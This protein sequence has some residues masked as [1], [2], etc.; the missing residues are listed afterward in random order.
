MYKTGLTNSSRVYT[1]SL[2]PIPTPIYI[3]PSTATRTIV[4]QIVVNLPSSLQQHSFFPALLLILLPHSSH[5]QSR[6]QSMVTSNTMDKAAVK[7]EG[8]VLRG[9][10]GRTDRWI[11]WLMEV[12]ILLCL[13]INIKTT[14]TFYILTLSLD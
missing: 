2:S 6:M 13:N 3:F 10:I 1:G 5:M 11:R 8:S 9:W 12:R 4:A 14:S 7:E